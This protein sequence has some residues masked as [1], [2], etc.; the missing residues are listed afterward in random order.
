[1]SFNYKIFFFPILLTILFWQACDDPENNQFAKITF[2]KKASMPG[3][4]R[5]SAVAFAVNGKGYVTLGRSN[6]DSKDTLTYLWEYNPDTDNWTKKA[7]FPGKSR[8]KGIAAVVNGKAY[9]GLGFAG[10]A[11]ITADFLSDFW[12]YDPLIDTW[13]RMAGFPG[14]DTDGCFSF[15]F[16][17]RIY[18]GSGYSYL[19]MNKK[20]WSFEPGTN[21]WR[22]LNDLGASQRF[23]AV[24]CSDG[25]RAYYGTGFKAVNENDWWEYN[26]VKDSWKQKRSM[27]DKGRVSGVALSVSSRFFVTTGRYFNGKYNLINIGKTL[28]DIWE[29]D[30]DKNKWHNR[31]EVP[32]GGRENAVSFVIGNKAYIGLGD[33]DST[34]LNDMY[35]FEP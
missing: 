29:Y 3:S 26:A 22:Q 15:V 19:N 30:P 2:D 1:M 4:G 34:V 7:S 5:A 21:T 33:N 14:L 6:P 20:L 25:F 8:A 9:V 35:S 12:C 11:V 28:N 16:G 23:G 24:G 27:P 10:R 18:V 31:G 17:D 13:I 32:G